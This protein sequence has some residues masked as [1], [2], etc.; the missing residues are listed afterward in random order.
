M[1]LKA[2][3]L[4]GLVVELLVAR[5][6]GLYAEDLLALVLR[7]VAPSRQ[8]QL[9]ERIEARAGL[10]MVEVLTIEAVGLWRALKGPYVGCLEPFMGCIELFM[11]Y[12]E[13]FMA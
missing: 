3:H 8:R 10:R 2:P 9:S 6:P 11:A 1:Q 12:R 5:G 7:A 13:P 4:P